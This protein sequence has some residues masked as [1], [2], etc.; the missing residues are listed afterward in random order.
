MEF[1]LKFHTYI[2]GNKTCDNN[3]MSILLNIFCVTFFSKKSN[4]KPLISVQERIVLTK[5]LEAHFLYSL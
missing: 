5:N 3:K 4:Y 1:K 2:A